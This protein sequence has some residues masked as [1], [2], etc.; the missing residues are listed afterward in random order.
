MNLIVLFPED[1]VS[2]GRVRLT[3]RRQEHVLAIHKA[4]PNDVLRVGLVNGRLGR[5]T[6]TRID[7]ELLDLDVVFDQEPPSALGVTL[8][9]SLPR[10]PVIRR[11]ILTAVSLGVKKIFL[12]NA[13]RVEK[14]FWQSHALLDS[15]LRQQIILG[16]EQAQDTVWPDIQ[17][18]PQFKPFV[19]DELPGIIA[20]TRAF[21]AHPG[22]SSDCPVGIA[23]PVTLSV[24]P[25][26]GFI[27]FEVE[28][29]L[30]L[31]FEPVSLGQRILRVECAVPALLGRFL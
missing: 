20:G 22:P 16:L 4:K 8:I 25:E 10:P 12:I 13:Y 17:L 7:Q 24:G 18:R 9:L 26:G 15:E 31:G 19:E 14:T 29:F 5:G 27:P 23:G 3:G 28:K 1:F 2:E 30:S 11:T 21:L 6:I